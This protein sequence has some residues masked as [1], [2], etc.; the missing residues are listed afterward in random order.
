MRQSV[1][2]AT[3]TP[4]LLSAA[5]AAGAKAQ[6]TSTACSP[7]APE[8]AVAPT[9]ESVLR[10]EGHLR[11]FA[12]DTV[13]MRVSWKGGDI[14]LR[15]PDSALVAEWRKRAA[16]SDP[17]VRR[18]QPPA[19][20]AVRHEG[21]APWWNENTVVKGATLELGSCPLYLACFDY[22]TIYFGI[23]RLSRAGAWGR[24]KDY[25]MGIGRLIDERGRFLKDPAGYFCLL[26]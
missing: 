24:W 25:Q 7:R 1:R 12:M 23:E 5:F 22:N 6:E 11:L 3:L 9:V 19:L 20:V 2:F 18:D 13:N 26:R 10:L 4:L 21:A 8:D 15:R 16:A 17:R 14:Q